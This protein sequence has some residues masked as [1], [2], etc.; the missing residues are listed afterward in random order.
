MGAGKLSDKRYREVH[1]AAWRG[2]L[3]AEHVL[4]LEANGDVAGYGCVRRADARCGV[5]AQAEDGYTP[6][7][8]GDDERCAVGG[9]CAGACGAS[10]QAWR[11]TTR[12]AHQAAG[13][14]CAV[15]RSFASYGHG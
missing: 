8:A 15:A 12:T 2:A 10:H 7:G 6:A 3:P 4:L 9:G 1:A 11:A 13:P 14:D 5:H